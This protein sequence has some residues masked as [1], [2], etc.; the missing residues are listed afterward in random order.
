MPFF[1]S[2]IQ[3]AAFSDRLVT[4]GQYFRPNLDALR[5]CY[6]FEPYGPTSGLP[7]VSFRFPSSAATPRAIAAVSLPAWKQVKSGRSRHESGPHS[8][9]PAARAAS[10][11]TLISRS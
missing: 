9:L 6:F 2:G 5:A 1:E 8:L 11:T 3:A 4:L 7:W 10:W